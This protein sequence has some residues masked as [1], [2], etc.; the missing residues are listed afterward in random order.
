MGWFDRDP[1]FQIPKPK[2]LIG[3]AVYVIRRSD[4]QPD[5]VLVIHSEQDLSMEAC[6][7]IRRMLKET[8][9]DRKVVVISQGLKLGIMGP[10]PSERPIAELMKAGL[11]KK[12]P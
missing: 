7:T 8:F 12:R 6:D 2:A 4:L 1:Q 10:K 9:P 3:D 5:D 11:G